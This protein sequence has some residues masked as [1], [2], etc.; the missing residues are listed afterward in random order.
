MNCNTCG[1]P[2][3]PGAANCPRCGATAPYYYSSTGTAQNAPTVVSLPYGTTPQTP[4]TGYGS[5]PYG[6]APPLPTPLPPPYNPPSPYPYTPYPMAP[7]TPVPPPQRQGTRI[8][9]IVGVVLLV[10]I[11]V[12]G[13]VF[14]L[15]QRSESQ[16]ASYI[17]SL[18]TATAQANATAT[19]SSVSALQN[20]YT[21]SGT[22]TLSD[23]L[24]DN[25]KGHG[26]YEYAT[27]CVFMGGAYHAIAPN[28]RFGDYCLAQNTDFSNFA[29]EVQM[30]V[31]KGDGGGISFRV[32]NT[33]TTS[34]LYTFYIVQDGSYELDMVNGSDGS[35]LTNG[36]SAV[37]NK[38]LNQ[39]NLVAVVAHGTT[40]MLY[41]NH[42]QIASA[43]DSTYSHGPIGLYVIPYN[44]HP[45]EVVFSNAKVW[46]L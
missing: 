22:L 36:S 14:V 29:F 12:G 8:G 32:E 26:W 45:T 21:H 15:L 35:R 6:G 3:P 37:I 34:K 2:L 17:N 46:T 27:N 25:S 31:I 39:S 44:N 5:Q 18:A 43:T 11:L 24:S 28:V 19:A 16:R 30:Q 20:P 4:P 42:Q 1:T 23:P 41:V 9:V 7:I 13:G 10:L 38:G 40:I 33:T